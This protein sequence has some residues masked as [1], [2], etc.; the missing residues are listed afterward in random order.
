MQHFVASHFDRVATMPRANRPDQRDRR[1]AGRGEGPPRTS[2]PRAPRRNLDEEVVALRESGNSYAF[3]AQALGI[4]RSEEARSIFMRAL[5][6]QPETERAAMAVRESQRLDKLE[7]RI[8][9]RD[10][11]DP[12]KMNRRLVALDTLR[13]GL[14]VARRA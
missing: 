14:S 1:D 5:G 2:R 10:A 6:A 12:E 13:E 4:K 9:E 7:V 3:I 11:N 8:R